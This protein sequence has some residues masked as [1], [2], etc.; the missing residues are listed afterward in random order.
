MPKPKVQLGDDPISVVRF[1]FSSQ[2]IAGPDD[3]LPLPGREKTGP[4]TPVGRLKV[5]SEDDVDAVAQ[6]D[7][8]R[9]QD[10]IQRL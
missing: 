10:G 5:A 9:L 2:L 6:R 3:L 1:P 4:I 7:F 8:K